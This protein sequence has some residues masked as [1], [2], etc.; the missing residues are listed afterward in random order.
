MRLWNERK[1]LGIESSAPAYNHDRWS[2]L[3]TSHFVWICAWNV[4][5]VV[6]FMRPLRYDDVLSSVPRDWR[7][8]FIIFFF[9]LF[10]FQLLILFALCAFDFFDRAHFFLIVYRTLSDRSIVSVYV[11]VRAHTQLCCINLAATELSKYIRFFFLARSGIWKCSIFIFSFN[12]E[13]MQTN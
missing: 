13:R 12:E 7:D 1:S 9:F 3:N 11:C 5:Y 2:R 10:G 6:C 8:F 4:L